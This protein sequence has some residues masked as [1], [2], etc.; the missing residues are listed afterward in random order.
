VRSHLLNGFLALVFSILIWS[1]VGAQLSEERPGIKIDYVISVPPDVTVTYNNKHSAGEL[2]IPIEVDVRG[3]REVVS[4][5]SP[6]EV[7]A[8][9]SFTHAESFLREALDPKTPAGPRTLEI[10]LSDIVVARPGVEVVAVRE[11]QLMIAFSQVIDWEPRIQPPQILGT[12]AEGFKVSK[13][14]LDRNRVPVRGPSS[15][16]DAQSGAPFEVESIDVSGERVPPGE[17]EWPLRLTRAV[18]TPLGV[19]CD[20]RV[21]VTVVIVADPV[22]RPVTFPIRVLHALNEKSDASLKPLGVVVEPQPPQQGW[23][24][25]IPLKGPQGDLEQLIQKLDRERRNPGT[26]ANLPVAYISVD[27]IPTEG[28][29]PANPDIIV[30]GLPDGIT[31]DAGRVQ[32]PIRT[33]ARPRDDDGGR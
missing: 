31:R 21:L 7:S 32:F 5:L 9:R 4:R 6:N 1:A 28:N 22:S 27:D 16:R 19:T 8:R 14:L 23:Y 24:F 20:A 10:S 13:V 17:R 12:P 2:R 18:K 15:I 30:I 26:Q 11:S 25:P 3:P 33:V 29:L